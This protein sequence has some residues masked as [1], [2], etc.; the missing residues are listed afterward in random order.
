M[1]DLIITFVVFGLLPF[2]LKVPYTGVLLWTWLSDM[3]PHRLTYGFAYTMPFAQIVA[4][5][6]L[7]MMLV[8]QDRS[9]IPFT[10]GT[11]LLTLLLIHVSVTTMFA[12]NPEGAQEEWMRFFKTYILLLATLVLIN[13]Q[14]KLHQLVCVIVFSFIFYGVKG[15][16]FT[17]ATGGSHKIYGPEGSFIGDNNTI[18]LALLMTLPLLGYVYG[19]LTSQKMRWVVGGSFV[20]TSIAIIS[21]YSRGALVAGAVLGLIFVFRSKRPLVWLFLITIAVGIGSQF[22]SSQWT[23]RMETIQTYDQDA[24]TLGRFNAWYFA[25]KV[26]S[27]KPLLG[28]GP[29]VFTPELFYHY[30]PDPTDYHDAHSIYFEILGEN[31]FVGLTLFLLIGISSLLT[32]RWVV[33]KS[34]NIEGLSQV[35]SLAGA[36]YLSLIAYA[37]GGA[38]LGL[39]YFD[40]YYHLVVLVILCKQHVKNYF[41][42]H[43]P[44]VEIAPATFV[45]TRKDTR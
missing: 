2:V 28:G 4:L 23:E 17:L 35:H 26:A 24:S 33:K 42:E 30:A 15:G 5:V 7:V 6:T 16:L 29:R 27:E 39:A 20:L 14:E 31:G 41:I 19:Q 3:N 45:K 44:E 21:T 8:T 34:K 37:V 36:L 10:T 18:A 43:K 1:R 25:W 12:L 38:F 11:V 40:Y 22:V 13:K 32:C 9:R